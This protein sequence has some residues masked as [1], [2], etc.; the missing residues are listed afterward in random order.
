MSSPRPFAL[1]I[2]GSDPSGGA[3]LLADIKTFEANKVYGLGV[4]TAVTIQNEN[5]FKSV[6]WLSS[7]EIIKQIEIITKKYKIGLAKIGLIENL[8]TLI[9]ISELLSPNS[10]LIWDPILKASAGFEFH[11]KIETEKL[12]MALKNIFLVTPN[13]EE[14]IALTGIKDP[15]KAAEKL[16]MHCNVLLKGGH[17]EHVKGRDFLFTRE[18]KH[19]S[20]RPGKNM[21]FPKHGSGCVLS[22]AITANLSKGFNLHAACLRAKSYTEKFLSSNAMLLGYH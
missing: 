18:K 8:E 20:F 22:A 19:Y 4:T 7:D 6:Q 3:G 11:K 2:A 14:A 13:S 9:K 15:L 17:S 12:E 21:V 10:L 16:S 5:E 1:S